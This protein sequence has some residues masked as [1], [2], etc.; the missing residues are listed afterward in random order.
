MRLRIKTS[1]L[2]LMLAFNVMAAGNEA[3]AIQGASAV[4]EASVVQQAAL[5]PDFNAEPAS[6][7]VKK[8]VQWVVKTGDNIRMPF[9]LVDK[10]NAHI[11]VFNAKGQFQ[12]A[13][14]ALLGLGRGDMS[15]AGI[16]RRALSEIPPED[17]ITPAGRFVSSLSLGQHGEEIL[18]INYQD[19]LSMHPVVKGTKVER[20]AERLQSA[21]A[22]DNRISFGCINIPPVFFSTTI[23][24]AFKNTKGIVYILP[25][26]KPTR[27]FFGPKI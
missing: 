23:S 6:A 5:A 27:D 19:A 12:G 21:T 16:G 22:T 10:V 11:Y 2:G 15:V 24:T 9:V 17:R 20:R 26:V 18:V 4:Q 3:S 14:P 1:V 8:V 7:E 25:E 13:A